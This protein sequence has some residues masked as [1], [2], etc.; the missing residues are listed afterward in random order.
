VAQTVGNQWSIGFDLLAG[1]L[2]FLAVLAFRPHGIF[3]T[4]VRT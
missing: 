2:V 3:G 1:H 4:G